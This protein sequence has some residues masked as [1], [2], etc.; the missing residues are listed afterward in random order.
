MGVCIDLIE[1]YH[2][3]VY[4]LSHMIY[5]KHLQSS[6]M[7]YVLASNRKHYELVA[8][9]LELWEKIVRFAY[10]Y[11]LVENEDSFG[12]AQ[13]AFLWKAHFLKNK[14][15]SEAIR[16]TLRH[17]CGK[18]GFKRYLRKIVRLGDH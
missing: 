10:G 5:P 12:I 7:F 3:L 9:G 11:W 13:K 1:E 18:V 4:N 16:L 17:H 14:P 6:F 8:E 15:Y 2:D